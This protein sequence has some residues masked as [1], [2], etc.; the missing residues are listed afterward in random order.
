MALNESSKSVLINPIVVRG[1]EEDHRA[2]TPLELFYDLVYV[3]AIASLAAQFH[4]KISD[5]EHV[6]YAILM[7]L[8][9]FWCIWWP[10]NTYTWFASGYDTDD[11]QFRLASFVQMVGAIIIA[12][13]VESA[14]KKEEFLVMMVGYVVMRLPYVLLWLKVARDDRRSRPIALRYAAGVFLVQVGWSLAVLFFQNWYVM[15]G[16]LVLEML[17]PLAAER[18]VDRGRNTSYHFHHIEER[19]G[20][21]TII[22]LGESILA[23]VYAFRKMT[24]HY[25][26]EL[27]TLAAGTLL[28]LFSMW[29]LYFDDRVADELADERKAFVWGYGH[30]FVFA[31]A[32]AVGALISVNVDTLTDHATISSDQAVVGLAWAIA[33]YLV[34]VWLCHDFLIEKPGL[35]KVELLGLAV[36][37]VVVAMTTRSVLLIGLTFVGLNALRLARRHRAHLAERSGAEG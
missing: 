35:P 5:G 24:E 37:V 27:A 7:Y 8:W 17:V 36:L 6:G 9:I 23:S 32:T 31:A 22:V 18:S 2:A 20:L 21:L 1:V 16:L 25:T 33:A 28:I 19:L 12:V 30:Y 13:G 3:V 4:H 11:A 34:A 26:P 14:F 10:W 29:W 15:G